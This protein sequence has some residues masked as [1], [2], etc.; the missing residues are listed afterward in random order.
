MMP[1][2]A[3]GILGLLTASLSPANARAD[4]VLRSAEITHDSDVVETN[5]TRTT[6]HT[7]D[8]FPNDAGKFAG[9]GP[10]GFE[11]RVDQLTGRY[12]NVA[13]NLVRTSLDESG[14][15]VVFDVDAPTPFTYHRGTVPGTVD[16]GW[17]SLSNEGGDVFNR[18]AVRDFSGVLAPGHYA[19]S[20]FTA[21]GTVLPPPRFT[22]T[23]TIGDIRLA[24]VPEPTGLL[25]AAGLLMCLGRR[26]RTRG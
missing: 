3:L 5:G 6:T 19:F 13:G 18:F 15:A 11:V 7:A 23:S 22:A 8:A 16:V 10:G 17:V 4:V 20:G 12:A 26:P 14:F 2:Y 24:V 9:F 1:R 21:A 25:A